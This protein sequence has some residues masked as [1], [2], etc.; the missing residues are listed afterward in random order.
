M[1]FT[2][3]VRI[4]G[5]AGRSARTSHFIYLVIFLFS[6]ISA[7]DYNWPTNA[8]R[9]LTAVF[10]EMRPRRYHAGL[11][12]RT[13][14][15]SG[16][17]IYALSDGYVERV[18]TS[19]KGYGKALYLKMDDG[20]TAVYAHLERFFPELDQEVRKLQKSN[21]KYGLTQY[22]KP[23][24]FRVSRGQLLGYTG[25][26]GSIGGPHLHFELRDENENPVN[27]LHNG[28]KIPDTSF[29]VGKT[30]AV[31]PLETDSR[32]DGWCEPQL[33]AMVRKSK[34][35]YTVIDTFNVF[36]EFGL[37]A[38]IVDRIDNQPF[39]YSIHKIELLIDDFTYYALNYDGYRWDEDPLVFT[40]KDFHLWRMGEGK[41]H[42]LFTRDGKRVSFI[43]S[44]EKWPDSFSAGLHHYRI[45]AVDNNGNNITVTG[46]FIVMSEPAFPIYSQLS[47]E[48][49]GPDPKID[50]D[51]KISEHGLVLNFTLIQAPS[52]PDYVTVNAVQYAYQSMDSSG[53]FQMALTPEIL[54]PENQISVHWADEAVNNLQ[55]TF[56]GAVFIPGTRFHLS[57]PDSL[58]KLSGNSELFYQSTFVTADRITGHA[59]DLQ[60][61]FTSVSSAYQIQP[62]LLPFKDEMEVRL[63]L[64]QD[65]ARHTGLFYFDRPKEE[66]YYLE[67]E[68]SG[69]ELLTTILSAETIMALSETVP[70]K[71][72]KLKPKMGATYRQLDLE[73]ISFHIEDVLS[74]MDGEND[75][76]ILLNGKVLVFEFN[77][78]RDECLYI[79]DEPLPPGKHLLE[80]EAED[81]LGNTTTLSNT[82]YIKG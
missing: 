56:S 81:N 78:Y 80:I 79:L 34:T 74:G 69:S 10:G 57:T 4:S 75:V 82:F 7:Q 49:T 73:E 3:P 60:K 36:G 62:M 14:G 19:S 22:F 64:E 76:K 54:E 39:D 18:R 29:P 44:A 61:G 8:S 1:R 45:L 63:L 26:T 59:P 32:I 72:S 15:R 40:E 20:R 16:Y 70:P 53:T 21:G 37:A 2:D 31:L 25:D 41:F 55:F 48:S 42:R 12:I 66:W 68:Q 24:R 9:T 33:Y 71:I 30:L 11:D 43:K 13:F 67:T 50:L 23:D 47:R 51:V 28:L 77:S 52:L 58:L 38:H 65:T 5:A 46:N 27:P 35:V 17:D 6:L